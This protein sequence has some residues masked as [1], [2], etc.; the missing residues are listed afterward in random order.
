MK[1]SLLMLLTAALL[2]TAWGCNRDTITPDEQKAIDREL[3]EAYIASIVPDTGQF[4]SSGLYYVITE[5][6]TDSVSPVL[7]DT[8]SVIYAGYLLNGTRFD[9]SNG[10]VVSFPLNRLIAGWQE[11]LRRFHRGD[12]GILVIPSHLGY[13]SQPVGSI[14]A[15]SVLRFDIELVDF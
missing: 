6:G 13:G 9:S 8:V 7:S 1:Q 3:I 11:G 10:A 12:K 5:P 14:P 2:A 4:T 15:N